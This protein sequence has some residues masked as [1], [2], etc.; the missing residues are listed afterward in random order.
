MKN[1]KILFLFLV[2]TNLWAARAI[3]PVELAP[4]EAWVKLNCLGIVTPK[5]EI[6]IE[7]PILTAYLKVNPG[8]PFPSFDDLRDQN[9][10]FIKNLSTVCTERRWSKVVLGNFSGM[11]LDW[12]TDWGYSR[13]EIGE[14]FVYN[15]Q[16]RAVGKPCER[17]SQCCGYA[18]RSTT[19]NVSLHTCES[20][21]LTPADDNNSSTL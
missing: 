10:N 17:V 3:N 5:S 8:R 12:G 18:N 14:E 13:L 7:Q 1:C 21:L 9:S 15:N 4:S 16:C 19:C 2:C 11:W 6:P 20:N